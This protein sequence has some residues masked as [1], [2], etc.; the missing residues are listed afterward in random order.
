MSSQNPELQLADDFVRYTDCHV[1]LTGKAGTGKTTFLH[2]VKKNTGKRL[3][4][5]AP[6]G[7]AAI[8]AGGVTLHSF[9]QMPLA[10]FVPGSEAYGHNMQRRF[11]KEKIN[12]IKSL[13]LLV[14]DEI[15]MVRA[16]LLDGVDAVLRRFRF[17]DLPFGGVQLLMIGDLHQLPPVVKEEEWQLLQPLY[18]SAYFFDSQSLQR[19]ELVNIELKHNYRQSD[20]QFIDLLNR[21]RDNRLDPVS[22]E[23]LNNRCYREIPAKSLQEHIILCT[24]NQAAER[25]NQERLHALPHK[26]HCFEARVEGD[27]PTYSHPTAASLELKK[28]ARVMFV[29]N[30][31]TPEKRYFN[32]KIGYVTRIAEGRLFVRC[33]GDNAEIEVEPVTW[34]NII[35]GMDPETGAI[36]A[37]KAGAFIQYPL[38]PAWAITI[39]KS[40]GLTLEKVIIDAGAAFAP[41]QIYVALSRCRTL[42]GLLLSSPL[43][44]GTL[45]V[46]DAVREFNVRARQDPPTM[47]R[48]AAAKV[49][50]QQR[51]LLQCFDCKR[52]RFLLNRLVGMI[53]SNS[54]TSHISAPADLRQAEKK[55]IEDVA[56]VGD[57]FQ[58]Q[59]QG[60]FAADRLPETDAVIQKRASKASAYF[61]EK[62]TEAAGF[63]LQKLTVTTDN[64]EV[65]QKIDK[66]RDQLSEEIAVKLAA[67]TS[68]R[69]GFSPAAYL[70]AVATA[71]LNAPPA[72]EE[73][74][75]VPEY[76]AANVDHPELFHALKKWRAAKA[77]EE[78]LPHYRILHQRVLIQIAV[79]LP[80]TRKD[81]EKIKGIGRRTIE[82]YGRELADLVAGYR[83]DHQ[84]IE[85]DLPESPARRGD[86][87][88]MQ[89]KSATAD[90]RRVSLE[91]FSQ[92]LSVTRIAEERGLVPATIE[93][94]LAVF[95]ERGELAIDRVLACEK[96]RSIEEKL[97]AMAEASPGEIKRTLGDDYSYGEIKLAQAHRTFLA[98]RQQP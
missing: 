62:L 53:L 93:G 79:Y 28:D 98:G 36:T 11:N 84:I 50:F 58:R 77:A 18:N 59:L 41:G 86:S 69:N 24:H 75:R 46:A 71:A 37:E 6:T 45:A 54:R 64:K 96:L 97:V 95:V 30:D 61:W 72:R 22:L 35:Y 49:A 42:E 76:T 29:R 78:E 57:N 90:T 26:T 66:A 1:F 65:R 89:E 40:Q 32:G 2:T 31:P 74:A 88:P 43:S 81:L 25:I 92:G 34:E 15:S 39:H 55:A 5:T 63:F 12:I 7:V 33:P 3:I 21:V 48:L 80:A 4:V 19:T 8:N 56:V 82:K 51:L 85:V 16:D 23:K 9:F 73:K 20:E 14:I 52:F 91:M 38:K 83:R 27:F 68:C 87:G 60:L 94:H 67:V 13:D 44:T 70:A 47:E 10:P 17:S